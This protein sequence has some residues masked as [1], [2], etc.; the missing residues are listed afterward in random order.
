V[1][2]GGSA[3]HRPDFSVV[4]PTHE[5]ARFIGQCVRSV[6]DQ[7]SVVEHIV[8]DSESTD[9]TASIANSLGVSVEV[10]AD[11]GMYD[12]LNHG[13]KRSSGRY[14]THLNADEQLLPGALRLV[15]AVLDRCDG[16]TIVSGDVVLVDANLRPIAYR[17]VVPPRRL[18]PRY[19]RM[20]IHTAGLFYPRSLLER[21]LL[22]FDTSYKILGDFV[23]FEHL[24]RQG[25][26][27]R[28]VPKPV[29][30]FMVHAD[31]LSRAAGLRADDV[32]R[33]RDRP[34]RAMLLSTLSRIP[35]WCEK[36]VRGC[37]RRRDVEVSLYTFGSARRQSVFVTRL[38]WR[39][40]WH[41]GE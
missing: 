11:G 5:A 29:A 26:R 8:E 22:E 39:W 34:F 38:G 17:R 4:T 2:E 10:R 3:H 30:V 19:A 36:A 25:V 13:L 9:G 14:L 1:R 12:A 16:N 37:Y 33:L 31:N 18:Y 40:K 6:Q 35:Y 27:F 32:A 21:G 24:L 23:L 20:S 7:Q 28:T 15:K 41:S